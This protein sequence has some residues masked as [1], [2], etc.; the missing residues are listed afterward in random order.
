[1]AA[2]TESRSRDE[3]D[4]EFMP[5]QA[6]KKAPRAGLPILPLL[7]VCGLV[8]L[9]LKA[10]HEHYSSPITVGVPVK[11]GT[12][13]SKCGFMSI[14]PGCTNAF[15]EVN[16][17]GTVNLFDSTPELAMKLKGNSCQGIPG[18]V[19]GLLLKKDGTILIGGKVVKSIVSYNKDMKITPWPFPTKPKAHIRHYA[20]KKQK[21]Q[22]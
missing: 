10:G 22:A 11:P 21:A 20:K 15:M 12:W 17:D 14:F 1:M 5:K 8:Y 6:E 4:V 18:C 3:P 16:S 2:K 9:I 19:D 7:V 13:R